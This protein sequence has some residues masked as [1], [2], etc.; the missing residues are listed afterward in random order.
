[1]EVQQFNILVDEVYYFVDM[2]ERLY[3]IQDDI[4]K[5]KR[6]LADAIQNWNHKYICLFF[7]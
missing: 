5:I 6:L 2:K 4:V 1:M 7:Q 3:L